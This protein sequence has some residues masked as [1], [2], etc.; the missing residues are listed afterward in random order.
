MFLKRI[1]LFNIS[2]LSIEKNK[3]YYGISVILSSGS[4]SR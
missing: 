3:I 4:H 1:E 2:K